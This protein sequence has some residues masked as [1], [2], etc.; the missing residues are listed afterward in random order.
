[1]Q[2]AAAFPLYYNNLRSKFFVKNPAGSTFSNKIAIFAAKIHK[3]LMKKL[4]LL[5]ACT[6]LMGACVS[7]EYDLGKDIDTDGIAIGDANSKLEMPLANIH[8]GINELSAGQVDITA[9]FND[10][11]AWIPVSYS[12]IEVQR[13]GDKSYVDQWVKDL[14]NGMDNDSE[15]AR[16]VEHIHKT[17]MDDFRQWVAPGTNVDTYKAAFKSSWNN[18]RKRSE[19]ENKIGEVVASEIASIDT[20]VDPVVYE[21]QNDGL[22]EDVIDMLVDEQ[23]DGALELFGPILN[24]MEPI[25]CSLKAEFVGS[26]VGFDVPL[27]AAKEVNIPNV[28]IPASDVYT[29][30]QNGS[31][32]VK[33]TLVKFYPRTAYPR[34]ELMLVQLKLRKTGGLKVN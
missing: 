24:K 9:L 11:E 13:L 33:V 1:L 6:A 34:D 17:R 23:N 30:I 21:I 7:N 19:L 5:T 8:V 32:Q 12:F 18:S 2:F 26:S 10:V 28:K 14:C 22:D 29:I 16:V 15:F 3:M 4:L 31:L 27:P 25:E 20:D